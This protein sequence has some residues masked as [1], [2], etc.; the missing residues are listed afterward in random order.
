VAL[1]LTKRVTVLPTVVLTWS[2]YP[3]MS[4]AAWGVVTHH[5]SP[6][7]AF[8]AMMASDVGRSTPLADRV[9]TP[10]SCTATMA[11][12]GANE[13]S[14]RSLAA[15]TRGWRWASA[16]VGSVED[17]DRAMAS[18]AAAV[19]APPA[20]DSPMNFR[21]ETLDEWAWA[22]LAGRWGC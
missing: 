7:L 14:P 17:G 9:A 15:R 13:A 19:T 3:S 5:R 6:C 2:A 22:P 1:V 4:P 21:R 20:A 12:P 18:A 11:S 16:A 8:S 10:A